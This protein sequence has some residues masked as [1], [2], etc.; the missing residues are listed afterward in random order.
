MRTVTQFAE[1]TRLVLII[2]KEIAR[3]P[4]SAAVL[5]RFSLF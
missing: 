3:F 4:A 5:M 1:F 2:K